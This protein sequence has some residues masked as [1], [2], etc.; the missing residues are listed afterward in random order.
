MEVTCHATQLTESTIKNLITKYQLNKM[1]P[2]KK[3]V[4]K[5][6]AQRNSPFIQLQQSGYSFPAAT[7][8]NQSSTPEKHLTNA[9]NIQ[10]GQSQGKRSYFFSQKSMNSGTQ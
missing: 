3:T 4:S 9:S 10:G 7:A 6:R 2:A 8:P 1:V 5:S